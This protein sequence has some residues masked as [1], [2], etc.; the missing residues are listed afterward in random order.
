ML[1]RCVSAFAVFGPVVSVVCCCL[2]SR[3]RVFCVRPRRSVWFIFCRVIAFSVFALSFSV[4][5][6]CVSARFSVRESVFGR[7]FLVVSVGFRSETFPRQNPS[8]AGEFPWRGSRFSVRESVFGRRFLVVSFGFRSE[9]F[10][11]RN[12]SA[13]GEGE[14]E[15]DH[16]H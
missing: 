9:T 11:R 13:A 14:G 6:C 1:F 3:E 15:D 2:L 4:R 8:A 16:G 10:P 5:F 12:P 7:R